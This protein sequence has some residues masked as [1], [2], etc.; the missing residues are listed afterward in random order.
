M[1]AFWTSPPTSYFP[2]LP[3]SVGANGSDGVAN[4]ISGSNGYI[5]YVEKS[6]ADAK[7]LP[8]AE[9]RNAAGFF[10]APAPASV[11]LAL[12]ATGMNADGTGDLTPVIDSTDARAYPLSFYSYG[13]VPTSSTDPAM[14]TD[15]RQLLADFLYQTVCTGQN[16]A[17]PLGYAPLPLNLVQQSLAAISALGTADAGVNVSAATLSGCG[18]PTITASLSN[19][20]AST[21]APSTCD[22]AGNGQQC[23]TPPSAPRSVVGRPGAGRAV[24]SWTAPVNTGG[25]AVTSYTVTATPGGRTCVTTGAR[26]CTVTGL[27]NGR[28]YRFSAVARTTAGVSARSALSTLVVPRAVPSAPRSLAVRL[29]RAGTATASWSAAALPGGAPILRY[30]VRWSTNDARTWTAWTSVSLHRTASRAGLPRRTA[31]EVEVRAVNVVGP[32][33]IAV[34]AF[35]SL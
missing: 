5:G 10:T 32:G 30:L 29:P 8:S 14:T 4:A 33:R 22:K 34:H 26:S 35:R 21:P 7:G 1:P 11:A 31:C 16:V 28:S 23:G 6:Y 9:I 12:R 13:L 19:L 18:N 25:L 20:E 17:A 3:G 24:V 27:V 2:A 15:K